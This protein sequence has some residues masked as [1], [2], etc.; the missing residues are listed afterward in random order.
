MV[1]RIIAY[2]TSLFMCLSTQVSINCH[3]IINSMWWYISLYNNTFYL[4]LRTDYLFWLVNNRETYRRI[5]RLTSS[6]WDIKT[7]ER[8]WWR[9]NGD[10]DRR[11]LSLWPLRYHRATLYLYGD[12]GQINRIDIVFYLISLWTRTNVL[13]LGVRTRYIKFSRIDVYYTCLCYIHIDRSYI[14]QTSM[15]LHRYWLLFPSMQFCKL[16]DTLVIMGL[17]S[18]KSYASMRRVDLNHSHSPSFIWSHKVWC[19]HA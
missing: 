12:L 1:V 17:H 18:T 3:W 19:N 13:E 10:S 14:Q 9:H 7:K 6:A 11:P 15:S 4:I 8:H 2:F 5:S 16:S